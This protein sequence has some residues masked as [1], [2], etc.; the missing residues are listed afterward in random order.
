V[1]LYKQIADFGNLLSAAKKA[2]RGKKQ[3]TAVCEFRY[4][5]ESE[6]LRIKSELE[7]GSYQPGPYHFFQ[8]QDPKKRRI[9]VAPFRDRVL[10]HAICN[11]LEPVLE[12]SMNKSSFACRKEKGSLAALQHAQNL[13]KTHSYFLKCDISKYF[14]SVDHEILKTRLGRRVVD[15]RLMSLLARIIDTNLPYCDQGKGIPIGNLTSQ[16]FANFYLTPLDHF[17]TRT[18]QIKAYCRYMDDFLLF[19]DEKSGLKEA[20]K[21]IRCFLRCRLRL[22]MKERARVLAPVLE[23]VPFLGFRL[24]PGV[25]R[26]QRQLLK[27]WRKKLKGRF[28]EFEK[29]RI[30]ESEFLCSVTSLM[31]FMNHANSLRLRQSLH[32]GFLDWEGEQG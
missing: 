1:K 31:G 3:T 4:D 22:S 29:F 25:I 30:Q 24:F 27:R 19:S 20:E 32:E 11:F 10:H 23:G 16:H 5:L 26:I 14:D 8:I 12:R 13:C 15:H 2:M 28:K 17:I 6:L 9:C 21:E 18:L 7:S